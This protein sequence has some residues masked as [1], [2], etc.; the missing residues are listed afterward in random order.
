[1]QTP[2][3]PLISVGCHVFIPGPNN[4]SALMINRSVTSCYGS[5]QGTCHSA[6]RLNTH[7]GSI[8]PPTDSQADKTL[9]NNPRL[10]LPHKPPICNPQPTHQTP[11]IDTSSLLFAHTR[12]VKWPGHQ[13]ANW[14][15]GRSWILGGWRDGGLVII[16]NFFPYRFS[17]LQYS[18]PNVMKVIT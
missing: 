6:G 13:L 16:T 2:E 1:M 14:S 8:P 10:P 9:Q 15:W 7:P 5:W 4:C 11:T 3:I 18:N 12:P 17:S